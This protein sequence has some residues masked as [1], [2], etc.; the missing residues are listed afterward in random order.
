MA[1]GFGGLCSANKPDLN[2]HWLDIANTR[3]HLNL[4]NLKDV[5]ERHIT[6]NKF[7]DSGVQGYIDRSTLPW[8]MTVGLDVWRGPLP[9]LT[10][11]AGSEMTSPFFRGDMTE[12]N[13]LNSS[14]WILTGVGSYPQP[15]PSSN[16]LKLD[17]TTQN[18]IAFPVVCDLLHLQSVLESYPLTG[19]QHRVDEL[20]VA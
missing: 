9:A 15:Y 18:Q 8:K 5:Q 10:G 14:T 3:Y 11:E 1:F 16:S 6:N 12:I 20:R 7:L 4:G 17:C 19:E 2:L 13:I